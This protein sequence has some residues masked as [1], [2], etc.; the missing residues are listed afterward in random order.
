MSRAEVRDSINR[1]RELLRE[2][3]VDQELAMRVEQTE[4]LTV[5]AN[6]AMEAWRASQE[7]VVSVE[8]EVGRAIV[9]PRRDGTLEAVPIPDRTTTRRTG[10]TGNPAHLQR[11]MEAHSRIAA[12][13]GLDAPRRTDVTTAGRPVGAV[14]YVIVPPVGADLSDWEGAMN[15]SWGPGGEIEESSNGHHLTALES[16]GDGEVGE[17]G[18][19]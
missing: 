7:D 3:L 5:V 15:R 2:E 16:G 6:E 8:V 12:L 11:A 14:G 4:A 19:D 10:Q 18:G 9:V 13:W 17:V 1:T